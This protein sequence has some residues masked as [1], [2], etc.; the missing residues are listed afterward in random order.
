[1]FYIAIHYDNI[2]YYVTRQVNFLVF[3]KKVLIHLRRQFEM[4]K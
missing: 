3:T 1:M 4:T 2:S